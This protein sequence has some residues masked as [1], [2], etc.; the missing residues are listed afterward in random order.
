MASMP[1]LLAYR[2]DREKRFCEIVFD[3]GE[4]IAV[5]VAANGLA[6][7][8][9]ADGGRPGETL[10]RASPAIASRIC[11]ALTY[12]ASAGEMTPLDIVVAA[13]TALGS[14]EKVGRAFRDAAVKAGG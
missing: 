8:L 14:A 2:N 5:E 12:P 10:F 6:I 4:R 3:D 11:A 9:L 1:T 13:V 7:D